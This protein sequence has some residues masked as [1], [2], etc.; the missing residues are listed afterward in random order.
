MKRIIS[1]LMSIALIMSISFSAMAA[2]PVKI[3]SY[4]D[5]YEIA[6]A[7]ND[8][9]TYD[10]TNQTFEFDVEEAVS[11]GLDA[12]TAYE[13]KSNLD[14]M[15]ANEA[16]LLN[17]AMTE[18]QPRSLLGT[19]AAFLIGAGFGW[20]ADKLLDY[21]AE[22]FCDSYGDYNDITATACEMLGF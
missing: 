22:K 11:Q 6:T 18:A 2:G 17:E 10:A 14:N 16:S 9:L 12:D 7:I 1:V 21:G 15:S 13:L 20:L 3:S 19:V 5:A 4:Q 8:N